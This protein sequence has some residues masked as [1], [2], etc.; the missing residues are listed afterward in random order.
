MSRRRPSIP[1]PRKRVT[2]KQAPAQSTPVPT[3]ISA[4]VVLPTA[5]GAGP[6]TPVQTS[7]G[8]TVAERRNLRASYLQGITA[9]IALLISTVAFIQQLDLNEDQQIL[10]E[11]AQRRDER[12][13]SSR[14]AIWAVTGRKYSSVLP[15]GFD[16][17]IQNRSPAP[18]RDVHVLATL[19]SG[20]NAEVALTDIPP[21]TIET[22]RIAAPHSDAF[23]KNDRRVIDYSR[24]WLEF[25]V[26]TRSWR[27]TSERLTEA[28][29]TSSELAGKLRNVPM[30]NDPQKNG[31]EV[32]DCGEGG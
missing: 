21:C 19:S 24:I 17:F 30:D 1:K 5:D 10:N 28:R 3:V 13:Y 27:L 8:L 4:P 2:G 9:V 26:D 25:T 22:H 14:V 16:M 23:A 20:Q 6:A 31:G 29:R 32:E 7:S 12:K 15:A 18:L 11:Y